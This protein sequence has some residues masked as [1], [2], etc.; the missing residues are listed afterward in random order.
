MISTKIEA[1]C[2][3]YHSQFG[4]A[5]IR[6]S[7]KNLQK[8]ATKEAIKAK[9]NYSQLA[10]PKSCSLPTYVALWVRE[11]LEQKL[12]LKTLRKID[13]KNP[14]QDSYA[15][16]LASFF[17]LLPL[18]LIPHLQKEIFNA[19][20]PKRQKIW[21]NFNLPIKD[22][23]NRFQHLVKTREK[24]PLRKGFS[25]PWQYS[26]I[27]NKVPLKNYSQFIKN[28]DQLIIH[29]NQKLSCFK[30]LPVWFY[31]EFNYPC[32]ICQLSSFPFSSLR[33]AFDFV[34]EEYPIIDKFSPKIKIE[35][36][37]DNSFTIYKRKKDTFLI[38]IGEGSNIRHQTMS[39]IHELSHVASLLASLSEG[40]DLVFIGGKYKVEKEAIK[41]ET[42]LLKKIS[43]QLY[44]ASLGD[45][46]LFPFRNTLFEIDLHQKPN[47]KPSKLYAQS[48]NRCFLGAKQKNNPLY[49]LDKRIISGPFSYLYHAIARYEILS[50]NYLL[51]K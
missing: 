5:K 30:N 39:L 22:I 12:I 36:K 38:N 45:V 23:E 24:E 25:P 8:L 48:F 42:A 35:S 27:K 11:I 13:L 51:V 14:G 47:Q 3:S 41:I 4:Q 17:Y 15:Q 44:F 49:L 50:E 7:L 32:F 19:P 29:L 33:E 40:K 6:V 18:E 34:A 20:F 1:I 31:D 9:K 43:L 37:K 28:V 26:L 10:K 2:Q 21:Q 46:L 16:A